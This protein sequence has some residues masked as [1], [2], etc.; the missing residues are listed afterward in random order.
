M[1]LEG[2]NVNLAF[3]QFHKFKISIKFHF[4]ESSC[5]LRE[6][7]TK[8]IGECCIPQMQN[9]LVLLTVTNSPF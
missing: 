1:I 8:A 3:P 2:L 9:L 6:S 5:Q 7:E 4:I